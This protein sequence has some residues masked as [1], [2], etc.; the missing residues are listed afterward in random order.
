MPA[1][2][3]KARFRTATAADVPA[4]LSMMRQ[5]YAEDGGRFEQA[6]AEA[7]LRGLLADPSLGAVW[8]A[9]DED[10][11]CGYGV[12]TIGYSLE[13]HG[14]D[15]FVDELFVSRGRRGQGLGAQALSLLEGECRARGVRA[16][17][18][19]VTASNE[20][21]LA[22]YRRHGFEMRGRNLMTKP[23]ER[24]QDGRW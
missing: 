23:F 18:L 6:P 16:L 19:E 5:L 4:L 15:A 14:R 13:F 17:H 24:K 1:P 3:G 20:S 10:G 2:A 9:E 22:L 8:I 7:A 11:A 21:A 12:M